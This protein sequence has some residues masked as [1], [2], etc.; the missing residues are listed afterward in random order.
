[1]P[2][3]PSP[4][5]DPSASRD[6]LPKSTP[7]DSVSGIRKFLGSRSCRGLTRRSTADPESSRET[8]QM[9]LFRSM[10]CAVA[11]ICKLWIRPC[12]A[13]PG[14][15]PPSS[16]GFDQS[17]ITFAGIK[18]VTAAEAVALRT[19]SIHAVER[20]RTRLELRHAD[21]AIRASQL[22]GIELL[23]ASDYRTCTRP[24]ANFIANPTDISRRCS[25]PGFTSRRSITTS[26]V[27][28]LR[29]SR[30]RSSSRFTSSPSTRARV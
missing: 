14:P 5:C 4:T 19:G 8:F 23:V 28:F 30:L 17:V 12:D 7:P 11:T 26:M 27:W 20:K 6:S 10:P 29:L 2:D 13:E 22:L 18:I 24:P 15:S 1:M 16:S 3:T 25:M 9:A 21:A